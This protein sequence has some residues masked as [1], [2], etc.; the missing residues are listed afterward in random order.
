MMIKVVMVEV[1]V[2]AKFIAVMEVELIVVFATEII[3]GS[4]HDNNNKDNHFTL[5]FT[6]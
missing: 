6:P 1:M 4:H 2:V 3:D 5:A